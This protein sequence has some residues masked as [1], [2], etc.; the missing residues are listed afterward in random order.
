MCPAYKWVRLNQLT[1]KYGFPIYLVFG[2]KEKE[3]YYVWVVPVDHSPDYKGFEEWKRDIELIMDNRQV[4]YL[5]NRM[6]SWDEAIKLMKKT[7]TERAK[8][9]ILKRIFAKHKSST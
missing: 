6:M 7:S 8:R 5:I 9:S 4:G 3:D 2:Q 1:K